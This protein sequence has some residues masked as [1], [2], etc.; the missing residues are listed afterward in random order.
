MRPAILSSSWPAGVQAACLA[1]ALALP[2]APALAC[3]PI[4]IRLQGSS[5]GPAMPVY[6]AS[7]Y[8]LVGEVVGSVDAGTRGERL[9][10]RVIE[11]WTPRAK[12]GELLEVGS[13]YMGGSACEQRWDVP[14]TLADY[15]AGSRL[16]LVAPELRFPGWEKRH[17]LVRLP[18]R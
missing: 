12:P 14:L 8:A 18:A 17:R 10:L 6:E 11:S 16:R 3:S 4:P 15:P 1:A 7:H 2:A 9:R 13:W 5:G